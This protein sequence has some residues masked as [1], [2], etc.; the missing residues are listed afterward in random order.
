MVCPHQAFQP[1]FLRIS[2]LPQARNMP[3]HLIF[4]DLII[5]IFGEEYKCG[6]RVE[7]AQKTTEI[8]S[9]PVL[10]RVPLKC[11]AC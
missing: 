9:S 8:S 3:A 7:V 6:I 10:P 4:L 5:L 2:H 11:M 1:Q